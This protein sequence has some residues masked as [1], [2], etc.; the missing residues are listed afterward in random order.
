MWGMNANV[1]QYGVG[2]DFGMRFCPPLKGPG[3]LPAGKGRGRDAWRALNINQII[4][5]FEYYSNINIIILIKI[6]FSI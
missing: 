5:V 1:P 6:S 3:R 4:I 2:G